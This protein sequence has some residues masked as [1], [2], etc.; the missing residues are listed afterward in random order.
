M[1]GS[2]TSELNTLSGVS[3]K[4]TEILAGALSMLSRMF[5]IRDPHTHGHQVRVAQLA[6]AIGSELGLGDDVLTGLQFGA[7]V[8]DVG[9]I[10]VPVELLTTSRRLSASELAII[11]THPAI[12]ADILSGMK[13]PWPIVEIVAQHHERMNGSGYPAGLKGDEITLEAR[14]VAVADIVEAITHHRPYRVG[15]GVETA[16]SEIHQNSGTLYDAQAVNA[17]IRVIERASGRFWAPEEYPDM[18][19]VG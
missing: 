13:F 15:L 17:C 19:A 6:V 1:T 11:R 4:Y 18:C 8:H 5:E 3:D 16:L 2:F 10:G 9:K 7:Q 14:I 12:G